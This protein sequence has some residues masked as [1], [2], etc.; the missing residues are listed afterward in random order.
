MA[1]DLRELES[2][3]RGT[4]GAWH[5]YRLRLWQECRS[6]NAPG[7]EDRIRVAIEVLADDDPWRLGLGLGWLAHAAG[8]N[9][10]EAE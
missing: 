5:H 7:V 3:L 9:P 4:F 6:I 10:I 8:R 2:R 1:I